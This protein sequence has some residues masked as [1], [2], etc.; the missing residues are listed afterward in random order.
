MFS[1]KAVR[2]FSLENHRLKKTASPVFL[3]APP[4]LYFRFLHVSLF[5]S[6]FSW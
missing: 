6:G 4:I 1:K 5:D 3:P 2:L